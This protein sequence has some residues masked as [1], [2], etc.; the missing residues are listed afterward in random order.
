MRKFEIEVSDEN[1]NVLGKVNVE[2]E[3]RPAR[4]ELHISGVVELVDQS[5]IDNYGLEIGGIRFTPQ[6]VK[7]IIAS[8]DAAQRVNW[9]YGNT[10]SP[11]ERSDCE[12]WLSDHSYYYY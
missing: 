11:W 2:A 9:M 12:K 10:P 3:E 1:G 7:A 6:Q 5:V 4:H 8:I